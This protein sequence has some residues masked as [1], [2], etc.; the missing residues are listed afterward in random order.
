MT[1]TTPTD[2]PH[3]RRF[4]AP[5]HPWLTPLEAFSDNYVWLIA[6][7]GGTHAAVVDPGDAA[8]VQAALAARGLRLAAIL[9]THH[10]ADHVGGVAELVERW[11][12]QVYGPA[13]EPIEH[14]AHRL[15]EGARG[16][17][18]QPAIAFEAIDV[19]GH[20]R[21]HIAYRC[22]PFG[23][24]ARGVLFCGDT[25]FAAGCGRLLE[26][27][28][29]QMHAS[30]GKLAALAD[31]TLVCCAHEYTLSNLRFACAVSPDDAQVAGRAEEAARVRATGAPTLPSTIGIERA[32][33]P[34]L[35]CAEPAIAAAAARH[36]Q[37]PPGAALQTFAALRAW[38]DVFR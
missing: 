16:A 10:H 21:G 6:P 33:N 38:K 9:L 20:T 4:V 13:G 3:A 19:P 37:A 32:T 35:R 7:P 26:G 8:P 30:L 15:Q 31:D 34:F 17:I 1:P 5:A 14:V 23:G 24:D 36:R 28:P 2:D 18:G 29:E 25:L 22:E 11:Q 27:T 12:P